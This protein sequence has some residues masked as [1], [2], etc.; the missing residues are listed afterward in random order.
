MRKFVAEIK[1]NQTSELFNKFKQRFGENG[2]S[3]TPGSRSPDDSGKYPFEFVH[4]RT[5]PGYV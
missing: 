4:V 3:K 2:A 1:A 5:N